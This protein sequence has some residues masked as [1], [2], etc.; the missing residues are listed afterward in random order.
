[1]A[2]PASVITS[3]T[4][5]AA[6]KRKALQLINSFRSGSSAISP[7]YPNL[8]RF[9]VAHELTRTVNNPGEIHQVQSSLCGPA[10]FFFSLVETRP[11]VYVSVAVDLFDNGSAKVGN[12]T[13][14][15]S[16]DARNYKPTYIRQSDWM[17]LSSIKPNYDHPSEQFDG[18]TLP[19]RLKQWFKDAGYATVNDVTNIFSTKGIQTLLQAQNDFKTGHS[20][21][22]F[23]D[24]DVFNKP[25]QKT[26]ASALPNHWV[27]LNSDIRIREYDEKLKLLKPPVSINTSLAAL[28]KKEM[29]IANNKAEFAADMNDENFVEPIESEDRILLNA[30]TWGDS[31]RPVYNRTSM[32]QDARL[33]YFLRGFYGYVKAKW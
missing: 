25:H 26:G 33:Y 15:S 5:Y 30:F 29:R 2:T 21:C 16:D 19:G 31:Q 6:A 32:S 7:H 13:L 20:V 14:K 28:I 9:Q 23:V 8:A 11:D 24:A 17:V 27:V 10:A 3:K 1:M 22:L 18:I 4:N 12:I